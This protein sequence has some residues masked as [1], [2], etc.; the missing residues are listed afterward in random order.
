[1][2]TLYLV[3]SNPWKVESFSNILK[4]HDLPVSIEML[5]GEY[6]ENKDLGTTEGVVLDGAKMCAEKYQKPVLVQ[7]TGLFIEA[8]NWFPGVNTK[9]F[10]DRIP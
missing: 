1:M 7:D 3:T 2:K 4:K 8:L 10:L 9:F 5:N 6:V